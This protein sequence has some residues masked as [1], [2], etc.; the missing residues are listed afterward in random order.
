MIFSET[1]RE[2]EFSRADVESMIA[3]IES[4]RVGHHGQPMSEATSP[5]ADPLNR[6]RRWKYVAEPW[7]DFA[8]Q[9]LERAKKK[10]RAEHGDAVDLD[11]VIWQVRKVDLGQARPSR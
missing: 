3:F 8:D 9:A 7:T 2:P 4:Q 5:L 6:D 1:T 11:G 10:F